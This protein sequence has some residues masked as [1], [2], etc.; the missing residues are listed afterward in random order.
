MLS[1]L[2]LRT[3][4]PFESG[5]LTLFFISELPKQANHG[6]FV[7]LLHPKQKNPCIE[8][9][10]IVDYAKPEKTMT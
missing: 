1:A 5:I 6:Y 4:S 10:P 3:H 9:L 8:K 2:T 7:F